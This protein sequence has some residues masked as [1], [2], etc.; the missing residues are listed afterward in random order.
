M[1][2][3][4]IPADGASPAVTAHYLGLTRREWKSLGTGLL[5]VSPWL[6]GFV[7]FL[8]YPIIYT[9]RISFTDYTGFGTPN[10]IG[11]DNYSKMVQDDRFWL[12]IYNTLYYTALAVPI[13]VVMAMVLALAMNQPLPEV[14][15]YRA[16]IYIPSVIPLF[17]LAFIFQILMNP[18]QG[19]FN[20]FLIR[21]GLPNINWF[22]DPRF[23]KLALVILAQYGAGQAAIIFLAGLKGIPGSLYEAAALDGAGVWRKFAN[24]TLPLMTPVILYD[25]P[26][27]TGRKIDT[28]TILTLAREGPN[29]V[30]VKD[31]AGDPTETARLIADAPSGFEVYSGDDAQTLPLLAVGAVGVISVASHWVGRQMGEMIDA[32]EKGD[33]STARR[34]N[35]GLLDSYDYESS[36]DA[37][38]PVPTKTMLRVLGLKVGSCRPPMGPAPDDLE[39]RARRVLDGLA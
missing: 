30:A 23:A 9:I 10:F 1:A 31:A 22:G 17:T 20:Q 38:N 7:V 32:F 15:V 34:I 27:R 4:A 19:I 21:L 14:P 18:T 26:V 25:I 36:P 2:T 3:R 13:G 11:L 5:F 6:A 39:D 28:S 16:I 12:A 29:I 8:L 24:I 35:A 37:V 33:V